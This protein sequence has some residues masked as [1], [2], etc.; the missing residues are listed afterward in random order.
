MMKAFPYIYIY[1]LSALFPTTQLTFCH[2]QTPKLQRGAWNVSIPVNA[3]KPHFI[4]IHSLKVIYIVH[5]L[6]V[7]HYAQSA[8]NF[9]TARVTARSVTITGK[10]RN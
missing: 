9:L 8:I 1:G 5:S 6:K 10:Y 4:I 2:C 3:P 7:Y